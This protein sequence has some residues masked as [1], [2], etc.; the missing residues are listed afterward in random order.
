M[1]EYNS[2]LHE[3]FFP[4]LDKS[5]ATALMTAMEISEIRAGT[6]LYKINDSADCLYV[7]VS[8]KIAVQKKTGFGDRMQVVALLDP[9]APLGESGLL[10]TQ[11]RGATLMVVVDSRL[12]VLSRRA[13]AEITTL[14]P[15]LAV[16]VLTWLMTR[17]S[18]RLKKSSERLAHVL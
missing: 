9:G 6:I 11:Y 18:L 7:L 1:A 17:L 3:D 13:F 16:K 14:T 10:D 4:F 5:E 12:L 8:G 2:Q 15:I